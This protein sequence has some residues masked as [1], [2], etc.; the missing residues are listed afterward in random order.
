[1]RQIHV[2]YLQQVTPMNMVNRG[3]DGFAVEGN[4]TT[5]E[6]SGGTPV[7]ETSSPP[8]QPNVATNTL[9]ELGTDY[10][11]LTNNLTCYA[12]IMN[13]ATSSTLNVHAIDNPN[14]NA[15][16]AQLTK[17][18]KYQA[19][20]IQFIETSTE[21]PLL[22]PNILYEY[23][24]FSNEMLDKTTV[25]NEISEDIFTFVTYS[26]GYKNGNGGVFKFVTKRGKCL[27]KRSKIS[28]T[29][30]ETGSA[31]TWKYPSVIL[32]GDDSIGEFY[33]VA[34]AKGH[35]QADTGSKMTHI[36]KNTKSTI[37]SKGI[38]A[39]KAENTYR[40]L[41]RINP[42]AENAWNFT[43]CDSLLIGDEC[44]AHTTP[45]V[46]VK[47]KSAYLEHEAYTS[48]VSEDQLFYCNSRGISVEKAHSMIINGFCE[49]VFKNLPFEFSVE[50]TRLL[51]MNL[52]GAVG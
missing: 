1:M 44:G 23:M 21:S 52:E 27:G 48:K 45:Y 18:G 3:G 26:D 33:S 47:N 43:Q 22:T 12:H 8:Q 16:E 9:E 37:I 34:L 4:W 41:V 40:G 13:G 5:F 36:G 38:S 10:F 14:D 28:W 31:I 20:T 6:L 39:G 7:D 15:V 49:Q 30:V 50:A 35:Q 29:Q 11:Y 42:G 17:E 46:E 2:D 19:G 24:L 51:E 25:D 32:Q